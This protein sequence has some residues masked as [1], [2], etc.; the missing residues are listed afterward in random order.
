VLVNA[1]ALGSR[2]L[3][4]VQD[5]ETHP[6]R[7]QTIL[8]K[9]ELKHIM[10]RHGKDYTRNYTYALPRLDGTVILG[11]I[12]EYGSCYVQWSVIPKRYQHV[13]A[14]LHTST[15]TRKQT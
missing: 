2:L 9:S 11:G 13:I 10:L 5:L 3:H 12:R 14:G 1:S 15:K 4:D 8:V 7:S 6:I